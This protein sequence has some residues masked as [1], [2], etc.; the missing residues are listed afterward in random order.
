[1]EN[2]SRKWL[3]NALSSKGYNVGK[4]Y[5]EF[6]SLMTNNADSRKWAFE[7]AKKHGYNVGKDYN[8]FEGLINPVSTKPHPVEAQPQQQVQAQPQPAAKPQAT[9]E[10][11]KPTWQEQM[12]FGQTINSAQGSIDY[13]KQSLD[14]TLIPIANRI[15]WVVVLTEL[16]EVKPSGTPKQAKLN[17]S[18]SHQQEPSMT[19]SIRHSR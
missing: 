18:I 7:T 11:Y 1:M 9:K 5:A 13:S 19:M 8:E 17:K 14:K 3:Y 12:A 4:D 16:Q 6:D 15:H 2:E 10:P